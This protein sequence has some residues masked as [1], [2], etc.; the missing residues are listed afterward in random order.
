MTCD[1]NKLQASLDPTSPGQHISAGP[2]SEEKKKKYDWERDSE[3][4]EQTNTF[5][6]A[7][8]FHYG[9]LIT[10]FED[11]CPELQLNTHE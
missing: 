5:F 4:T 8:R 2:H 1:P 6:C 9:L 11:L 3:M 7:D 10:S